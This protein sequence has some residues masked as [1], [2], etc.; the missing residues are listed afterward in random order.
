[1]D[2]DIPSSGKFKDIGRNEP[3]VR[4]QARF[5]WRRQHRIQYELSAKFPALECAWLT[6]L[7][8]EKKWDKQDKYARSLAKKLGSPEAHESYY[9]TVNF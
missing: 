3:K 6:K 4:I 8:E 1:M 9:I 2:T 5:H 7:L